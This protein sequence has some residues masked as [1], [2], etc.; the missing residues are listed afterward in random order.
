MAQRSPSQLSKKGAESYAHCDKHPNQRKGTNMLCTIL[1]TTNIPKPRR[2]RGKALL[3]GRTVPRGR[4]RLLGGFVLALLFTA[5]LSAGVASAEENLTVEQFEQFEARVATVTFQCRAFF[6]GESHMWE[7]TCNPPAPLGK[8]KWGDN[9]ETAPTH[10]KE[11]GCP[12][13]EFATKPPLSVK[14]SQVV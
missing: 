4:A 11:T 14:S 10:L 9:T 1:R 5:L 3:T 8:I 7:V 12:E 6:E 2:K 13:G